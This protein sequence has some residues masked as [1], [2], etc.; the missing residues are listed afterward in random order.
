MSFEEK[1]LSCVE[2]GK[3]FAFTTEE[4]EF[5][6]KKG[7]KTEP[8]RCPA[9]RELKRSRGG[10]GSGG[11]GGS[12]RPM[13]SSAPRVVHETTCSACGGK[14]EVPFK[15]RLDRPVYCNDCFAKMKGKQA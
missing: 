10:G 14:A 2:C 9:C 12:R 8:K 6:E 1:T 13:D 11:S 4:Q 7:Y 5:H 15:P 3:T